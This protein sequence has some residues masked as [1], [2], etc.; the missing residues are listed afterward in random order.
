MKNILF[1]LCCMLSFTACNNAKTE[2]T[3]QTYIPTPTGLEGIQKSATS[4]SSATQSQGN[5]GALN[6]AHGAPG[7]R[8]DI[9]VG[10]PLN[11]SP[12]QTN[13]TTQAPVTQA[14]TTA[15]VPTTANNQ[16]LNPA[17]G[18]PGHKC[19]IAVGA[20]LDSKPTQAPAVTPQV[21]PQTTTKTS[22][23][24]ATPVLNEK[25]Q[26]LNPAHGQPGHKCEIAVGA[27]LI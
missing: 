22:T 25:G 27:P 20:P 6:P 13:T 15:P 3:Q 9:A 21:A 10:A 11:S 14:T 23:P 4:A 18:Q 24:A 1:Y 7:H 19:E 26:R 8:C 5:N 12:A 16:K 2:P 17:H